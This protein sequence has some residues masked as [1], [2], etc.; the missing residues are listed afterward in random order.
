MA[1]RVVAKEA[2]EVEVVEEE[3]DEI[4]QLVDSHGKAFIGVR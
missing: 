3:A 4:V 1:K 2:V